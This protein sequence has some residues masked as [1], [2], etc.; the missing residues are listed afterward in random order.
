MNKIT[1]EFLEYTGHPAGYFSSLPPE[2]VFIISAIYGSSIDEAWII[3][4]DLTGSLVDKKKA[5][6]DLYVKLNR[7]YY[8]E[9][10]EAQVDKIIRIQSRKWR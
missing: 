9:L 3:A 8:S 4:E 5:I 6:T 1:Q 7:E 2:S 10:S